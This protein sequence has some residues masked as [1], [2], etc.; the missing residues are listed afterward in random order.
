VSDDLRLQSIYNA[1]DLLSN[2]MPAGGD[3]GFVYRLGLMPQ[4]VTGITLKNFRVSMKLTTQDS[5]ATPD[6]HDVEPY[7]YRSDVTQILNAGEFVPLTLDVPFFWDGVQ[8]IVIEVLHDGAT[9]DNSGGTRLVCGTSTTT[10]ASLSYTGNS[11][12][13]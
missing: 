13:R 8:N 10:N 3:G 11:S 5:F 12:G 4:L 2:G 7:F 1:A 9:S 6:F